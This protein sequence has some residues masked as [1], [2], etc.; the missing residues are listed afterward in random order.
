MTTGIASAPL[1]T[2]INEYVS[3]NVVPFVDRERTSAFSAR[4]LVLASAPAVDELKY[5]KL[6]DLAV[7]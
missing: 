3:T 4:T 6:I 1:S 7:Q 2:V 5:R